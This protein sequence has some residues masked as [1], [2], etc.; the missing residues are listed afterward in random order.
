MHAGGGPPQGPDVP[1]PAAH[2]VRT[3]REGSIVRGHETLRALAL[4]PRTP[5]QGSIYL[6]LVHNCRIFG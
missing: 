1:P 6:F 2:C 4:S 3:V 5:R